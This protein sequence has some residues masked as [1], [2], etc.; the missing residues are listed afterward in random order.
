MPEAVPRISASRNVVPNM[1]AWCKPRSDHATNT[2]V[3]ARG[4][5][6]QPHDRVMLSDGEILY[7]LPVRSTVR[8]QS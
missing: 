1:H 8:C 3:H 7:G 2:T 5:V 4:D 6:L